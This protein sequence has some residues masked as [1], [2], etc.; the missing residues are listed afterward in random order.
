MKHKLS[1]PA[2]LRTFLVHF[3]FSICSRLVL[4]VAD[5]SFFTNLQYL[6]TYYY[7][8]SPCFFTIGSKYY[9]FYLQYTQVILASLMLG[10]SCEQSPYCLQFL[11]IQVLFG[12]SFYVGKQRAKKL[13]T[14][15]QRKPKLKPVT[16]SSLASTNHC[17]SFSG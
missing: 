17:F 14:R 9:I 10:Q 3:T 12:L 11:P 13:C 2:N 1:V 4:Q 7:I 5:S 6:A 16:L 15:C 8:R